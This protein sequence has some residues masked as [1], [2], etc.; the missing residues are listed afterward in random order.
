MNIDISFILILDL[1]HSSYIMLARSAKI[2]FRV[3]FA[4]LGKINDFLWNKEKNEK[5]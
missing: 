1:F 3:L 2:F 4:E 5:S